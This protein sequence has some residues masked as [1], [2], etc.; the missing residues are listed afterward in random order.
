MEKVP[1]MSTTNRRRP[2]ARSEAEALTVNVAGLLAEPA[3]TVREIDISSSPLDMGPDL[4]QSRGVSGRLKLTRTNRGLLVQGS[5]STGLELVCSRCL[6][7]IDYPVVFD[8][9]EEALPSID[10]LSGLP[11]DT[12]AEPDVLRLNDHHELEL[13]G[14]IRDAVALAEPIAPLCRDDCPGLCPICGQELTAGPHEHPE[15][16]IDPRLEVLRHFGEAGR[17]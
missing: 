2:S 17:D 13:E 3:G 12:K 8:I 11:A 1:S 9:D 7:E 4:R 10:V 5:F 14:G 15:A 6:R 16:E